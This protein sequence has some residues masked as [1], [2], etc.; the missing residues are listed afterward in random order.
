[1]QASHVQQ[2]FSCMANPDDRRRSNLSHRS[3]G[4]A[5]AAR[6]LFVLADFVWPKDR[7]LVVFGH[8]DFTDNSRALFEHVTACG[9]VPLRAAWLTDT[10]QQAE[11]IA[12]AVPGACVAPKRS[13]RGLR[14][15]LA[16]SAVAISFYPEE[17]RPFSLASR[18][19]R[20]VMLWHAIS[21]KRSKMLNPLLSSRALRRRAEAGAGYALMIA[22]S[23]MDQL[24]KA[25]AHGVDA[26]KVAVTGLPRNDRLLY[27]T[28]RRSPLPS[29]VARALTGRSILHAPTYRP[30][31]QAAE[32]LPFDDADPARLH[33]FLARHEA[34]LLLRP[35]KNDRTSRAQGEAWIAAG[36]DRFVLAT[37]DEVPDAADLLGRVDVLVTD[38]SSIFLDFLMLDRPIVFVPHDRDT[39][40]GARGLL[41]DY[42]AITPGP[43]VDTQAGFEA[44]L[45]D[46]LDGAPAHAAHRAWSRAMFH[47]HS[48]GQATHRVAAAIARVLGVEA[49]PGPAGAHRAPPSPIPRSQPA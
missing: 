19:K 31:R 28:A 47:A 2:R 26:R 41:Y 1:M 46:A 6:A 18:R 27:P 14:L 5:L 4:I 35:H 20:V 24:A 43:K 40:L 39:Y 25:A 34:H 13:W 8:H 30:A 49:H 29:P 32:F 10:V 44:A 15:A 16:A 45:A 36:Y 42:D 21:I 3:F 38:H 37:A 17:F 48:D 7:R 33:A 12:V 9:T 11:A 23:N 22:S